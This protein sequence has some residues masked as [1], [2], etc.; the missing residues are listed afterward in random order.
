[1]SL[2][3]DMLRDLEARRAAPA[4]RERL[5]GLYAA[6][7]TAAARR[8]G[9]ARLRRWLLVIAA[10]VLAGI[11][12]ALLPARTSESVEIQP[13]PVTPIVPVSATT[14]LLEVLPQNDG[15]RFVLQLLLDRAVSYQRTDED[16]SVS[17]QLSGVQLNGEARSGRIETQGQSLSWRV[18]AHGDQVQV[19]FVGLA[20]RLQVRDR[21]ETAG[22]RWQLWLEVPLNSERTG[23][24]PS[25][26]LPVAEPETPEE[27]SLPEWVTREAPA[28]QPEPV[29]VS[30]PKAA[31]AESPA[32][33]ASPSRAASLA[34]NI[35]RHTPSALEQARQALHDGDHPRAIRELQA[36]HEAQPKDPQVV[37]WLARAYLAVGETQT[38]LAWLPAQLQARPFDSELRE[39]L[40]RTQLQGGD[41]LGAI[42]TLRKNPPELFQ[43]TAYHALLAALYQQVEDWAA[44]AAIYRQ[45]VAARPDQASWQ[46]GL[47]ISLEQLDQSTQASGHYQMALQGQ[48]LDESARRFAS[49]RAASL[50]GTQ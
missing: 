26:T 29:I 12:L 15:S 43:H 24:E 42:T 25:L 45:L 47:A 36:L 2:V 11:A 22:D 38:L 18:E 7:E 4:E 31:P 32:P 50:G 37:R 35:G 13:E 39:L 48:G 30:T 1:M 5:S 10:L 40:A 28:N 6:N 46:L 33:S 14:R 34:S 44:S 17:L 9:F 41:N 19:L 16:G 27:A 8:A 23:Q 49:E 21:L 20:E 3:N